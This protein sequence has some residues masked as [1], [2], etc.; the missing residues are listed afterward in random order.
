MKLGDYIHYRYSNYRN[1]G[2]KINHG[3]QPE[4]IS[5]IAQKLRTQLQQGYPGYNETQRLQ[6]ESKLNFFYDLQSG[7]AN[8]Q[9]VDSFIQLKQEL[10][11]YLQNNIK[12][13]GNATIDLNNLSATKIYESTGE[14]KKRNLMGE[15]FSYY[16]AIGIRIQRLQQAV[17]AASTSPDM[18]AKINNFFEEYKVLLNEINTHLQSGEGREWAHIVGDKLGPLLVEA[19]SIAAGGKTSRRTFISSLNE[20]NNAISIVTDKYLTGALGEYMA[21]LSPYIAENYGKKT[22]DELVQG[23]SDQIKNN[24]KGSEVSF[25][26]VDSSKVIGVQTGSIF[27]TAHTLIGTRMTQ[28]NYTQDKIDITIQANDNSK[29]YNASVKNIG[30]KSS[31]IHIHSGTSLVKFLQIY[32]TFGNHYLNI[33]ANLGRLSEDEKPSTSDLLEAHNAMV[34]LLGTHALAGGMLGKKAGID[35]F[36]KLG[37]ADLLIVN[38]RSASGRYSVYFI[39]ELLDNIDKY[40]TGTFQANK[41]VQW[42][43]K[44][45]AGPRSGRAGYARIYALL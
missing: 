26:G 44:Y 20:L 14:K 7:A 9:N 39:S 24:L 31:S 1:N 27:N 4:N 40:I 29:P 19:K 3:S 34:A 36:Q 8:G 10:L 5:S 6:L 38:R 22:M 15:Q 45:I 25:K 13:A 32:P 23:F 16:K 30:S 35:G 43:N 28:I 42:H 41:I 12:G 2:L 21:I 18:I 11:T 33:T 17:N 37:R